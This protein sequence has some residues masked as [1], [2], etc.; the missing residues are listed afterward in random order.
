MGGSIPKEGGGGGGAKELIFKPIN[1]VLLRLHL[2]SRSVLSD[3]LEKSDKQGRLIIPPTFDP[4][5]ILFR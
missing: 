4:Q 3:I 1:Q 5:N 2:G